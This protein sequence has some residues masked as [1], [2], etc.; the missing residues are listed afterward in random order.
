MAYNGVGGLERHKVVML[1]LSNEKRMKKT[2]NKG[3]L[4]EDKRA[5]T[6]GCGTPYK[7]L[8]SSSGRQLDELMMIIIILQPTLCG[9]GSSEYHQKGHEPRPATA[10]YY[11]FHTICKDA[12]HPCSRWRPLATA[13][14]YHSNF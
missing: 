12:L 9:V 10:F 6:V 1:S 2:K 11:P 3:S 14:T 5:R 7:R 13:M 4:N 8:M